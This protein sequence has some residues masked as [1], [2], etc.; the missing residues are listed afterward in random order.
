MYHCK[1]KSV[2]LNRKPYACLLVGYGLYECYGLSEDRIVH[3]M[4]NRGI[5]QRYHDDNYSFVKGHVGSGT[6]ARWLLLPPN[7]G[8]FK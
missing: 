8:F 3:C 5:L 6:P 1:P 4:S 2:Y 7:A